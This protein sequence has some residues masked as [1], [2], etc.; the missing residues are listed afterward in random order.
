MDSKLSKRYYDKICNRIIF[1]I[2]D[3]I[4]G[5][6]GSLFQDLDV[7]E[8]VERCENMKAAILTDTNSGID[9]IEASGLG[10]H[11]I[12]MPVIIDEVIY[13]EGK[14]LTEAMLCT[15]LEEGKTVTTSQP[16]IGDVIDKWEDL[17]SA[18]YEEIVYIPMSS[19][20]SSSCSCAKA[21][22]EDY[23]E[24]VFVVDNHRISVTQRA[25]VLKAVQLAEA[26]KRAKEITTYL[27]KDAYNS[28]IYVSVENLDYLK[29]G[30]R[31]SA[32]AAT[33]AKVLDIK[34][35]LTIQGEKLDSYAKVRGSIRRCERKMI[36][37][38]K[39]DVNTRFSQ[40][41]VIQLHIGVA[42]FG[43]SENEANR[44]FREVKDAFP[45][46]DVYYNWLPASIGTHTG[47]GTLGIGIS[48]DYQE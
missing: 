12:P 37:A 4:C 9:E 44:W 26:G 13:Y 30:G 36:D 6:I 46:A 32:T 48:T 17:L 10:I 25:A 34:P 27:E 18:G 14:N 24:K 40:E 28:S 21:A 29:K 23:K 19:G 8:I 20:L 39:A 47:P 42:G 41:N 35:V 45:E 3:D 15:L 1:N 2:A 16:S 33:I 5:R 38:I 7:R 31:I 11:V 22:A 43:I